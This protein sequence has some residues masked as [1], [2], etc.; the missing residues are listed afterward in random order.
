MDECAETLERE[1]MEESLEEK[2]ESPKTEKGSHKIIQL[3]DDLKE[4]LK[5]ENGSESHS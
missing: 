3:S 4:Q 2:P 1:F 5:E